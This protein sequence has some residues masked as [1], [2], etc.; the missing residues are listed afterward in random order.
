MSDG[1]QNVDELSK[2]DCLFQPENELFYVVTGRD[3]NKIN[4]ALHGWQQ[5]DVERVEQ[6]LT[7][8]ASG[9]FLYTEEELRDAVDNADDVHNDLDRLKDMVFTVYADVDKYAD[10]DTEES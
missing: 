2:G 5:V 9:Q 7:H 10:A 1:A 8:D 3:E 4:F 6:Y